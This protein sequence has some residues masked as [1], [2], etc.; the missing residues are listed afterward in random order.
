MYAP[1]RTVL[2]GFSSFQK[3]FIRDERSRRSS[4]R[5]LHSRVRPGRAAPAVAAQRSAQR[6][7][8]AQARP[9]GRRG[10]PRRWERDRPVDAR[11]GPSGRAR[12]TGGR[13]RAR[14]RPAR[15]GTPAGRRGREADL[16]EL[17]HG[18]ALDLPLRDDGMGHLRR[19]ARTLRARARCRP[20]GGR[21]RDG[22]GRS[23]RRPDRP[24]RRRP[25]HAPPL[26]RAARSHAALASL[27][28]KLRPAG[29]R[30]LRRP[31]PGRA[32]AR[33]RRGPDPQQLGFLRKL[34]GNCRAFPISSRTS[35]GSCSGHATSSSPRPRS[36][37][38]AF[39]QAIAALEH[40]SARP[41]AAFWFAMCWAEGS[42]PATA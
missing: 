26:A 23:P 39:D 25:R 8:A 19:G 20:A 21:P 42:R 3:V 22:S 38:H 11:D 17:R 28:P 34:R 6:R 31:S 1:S 15:R 36:T 41:D 5:Q 4:I 7:L 30:P 2:R 12:G 14:R 40:W 18:D 9:T 33:R 32:P 29:K 10:D 27:H 13:H 35:N 16:V 24:G 37:K